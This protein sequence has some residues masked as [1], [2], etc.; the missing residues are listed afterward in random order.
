M[1][2][3]SRRKRAKGKKRPIELG[4]DASSDQFAQAIE[5]EQGRLHRAKAI[6]DA[7]ILSAKNGDG[8]RLI[9]LDYV[10]E[11][12]RDHIEAAIEG[13]DSVMLTRVRAKRR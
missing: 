11:A 10:A 1:N 12:A 8:E 7:L 2:G 6:L 3:V 5:V 13:L 4:S 9:A